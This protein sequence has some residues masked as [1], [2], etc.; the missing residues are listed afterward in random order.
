[1]SK[2][3][4]LTCLALS[5]PLML[6]AACGADANKTSDNS[7][8]ELDQRYGFVSL[9]NG[10]VG[11]ID[12]QT[13]SVVD[14]VKETAHA[15]HMLHAIPETQEL[16]MGDWDTNEVI[17][18]RFSED[19]TSHE[20]VE[21]VASPVQMHGFMTMGEDHRYILVTSRL[22]LKAGL[23]FDVRHD[24]RSI[25]RYDRD[26]AKWDVLELDSPSY[27]AVGPDGRFYVA[28]VHH[29]SISVVDLDTFSLVNTVKV[30]DEDW[31]V[32]GQA[33]GP[34]SLS[35]SPDGS[36]L[37]SAD[38]EGMSLT[39]WDVT[40]EGLTNRRVIPTEGAPKA[41][42]FSPD[43]SELWVVVYSLSN[44]ESRESLRTQGGLESMGAWYHGPQPADEVNNAYR[45]TT[46]VVK[47]AKT[48]ET[49]ASMQTPKAVI[50]PRF[51]PDE[52]NVVYLTTSAG[53]VYSID[54]TSLKITGEALVGQVG[55]PVVCGNLAL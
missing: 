40:A 50:A 45:D 14:R 7:A 44:D 2:F 28:N 38:Y 47:D 49:V 13:M 6:T 1:M 30:G 12:L 34:K 52:S 23:M 27:A 19:Y 11:V 17:V 37:V 15:S 43:G 5:L 53:S 41:A 8:P 25:A 29:Q 55:L 9:V 32:D 51:S 24:D 35:F 36:K 54:R 46:L 42:N 3:R 26:T 20:V 31:G 21:R 4:K 39:V 22:E 18:V 33:I 16:V 10:S 48:L